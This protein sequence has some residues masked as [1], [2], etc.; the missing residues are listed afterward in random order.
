MCLEQNEKR[1]ER[2]NE[3]QVTSSSNHLK[4]QFFN[5]NKLITI[6]DNNSLVD[7]ISTINTSQ[8]ENSMDGWI[9]GFLRQRS[10]FKLRLAH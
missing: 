6:I 8:H 2:V 10:L 5:P 9:N 7:I 1:T 3:L 4:D